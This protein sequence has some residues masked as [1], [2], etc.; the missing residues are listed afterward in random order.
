MQSILVG[1]DLNGCA[2]VYGS[3]SFLDKISCGLAVFAL[4]SFQSKS[5]PIARP[6]LISSVH[7]K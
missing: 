7:K 5:S 3:L 2:F 4:Q 6:F 1:S